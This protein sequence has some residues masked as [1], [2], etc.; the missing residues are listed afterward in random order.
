M[1]VRLYRSAEVVRRVSDGGVESSRDLWSFDPIPAVERPGSGRFAFEVAAADRPALAARAVGA[2]I[3]RDW[4]GGPLQTGVGPDGAPVRVEVPVRLVWSGSDSLGLDAASV[5]FLAARGLGGLAPVDPDAPEPEPDP[6]P[7]PPP[8][9]P[10]RR[11]KGPA[12]RTLFDDD[13]D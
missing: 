11:R 8:P 5:A 1:I 10:R 2:R 6:L 3:V 7:P 4:R 9:P 12:Q 13:G